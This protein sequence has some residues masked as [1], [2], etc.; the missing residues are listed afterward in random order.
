MATAWA[1][2]E[3]PER[4]SG[5]GSAQSPRDRCA[6][7]ENSLDIGAGNPNLVTG[8]YHSLIRVRTGTDRAI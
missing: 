6:F 7:R 1:Y 5:V 3:S 8:N 2:L 4:I